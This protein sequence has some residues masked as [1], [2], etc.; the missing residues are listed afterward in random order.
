M[1]FS[2]PK[3][4][5]YGVPN[6]RTSTLLVQLYAPLYTAYPSLQVLTSFISMNSAEVSQSFE[7]LSAL[8]VTH[9]A[10]TL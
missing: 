10:L 5:T 1:C 3:S 4:Y 8:Y 7:Q 9:S 2:Q 6:F